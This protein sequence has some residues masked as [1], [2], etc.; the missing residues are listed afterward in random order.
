[1]LNYQ[2]VFLQLGSHL[3]GRPWHALPALAA[4]SKLEK[5]VAPTKKLDNLGILKIPRPSEWQ[6][7]CSVE[8]SIHKSCWVPNFDHFVPSD[9][10]CLWDS[11][12][13]GHQRCRACWAQG[14]GADLVFQWALLCFF[15]VGPKLW[16]KGAP[17]LV[18][19]P[20]FPYWLVVLSATFPAP[21][22]EATDQKH[23]RMTYQNQCMA[24]PKC[25]RFY[26]FSLCIRGAYILLFRGSVK[27]HYSILNSAWARKKMVSAGNLGTVRA[28]Q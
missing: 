22:N 27:K 10:G 11:S 7:P 4:G 24:I 21:T 6:W 12:Q 17:K 20:I 23:I 5:V 16:G 14:W 18:D 13:A 8:D 15:R 28:G 9:S 3:K 1:M 19:F 26:H 25:C 2:R